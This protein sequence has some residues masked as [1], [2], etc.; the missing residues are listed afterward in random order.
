MNVSPPK[1]PQRLFSQSRAILLHRH[2]APVMAL[3]APVYVVGA[4]S[5]LQK[6]I[7]RFQKHKLDDFTESVL[8]Y[9]ASQ[10]QYYQQEEGL[11]AGV[12]EQLEQSGSPKHGGGSR[13][14]P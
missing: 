13:D 3:R 7:A 4:H 12:A 10:A 11:W 2:Y 6:E 1:P 9:A 5:R 14:R 8:H